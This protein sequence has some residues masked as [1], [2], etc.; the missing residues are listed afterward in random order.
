[1]NPAEGRKDEGGGGGSDLVGLVFSHFELRHVSDF[2][3][4]II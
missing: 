2:M 1:M 4:A 3:R